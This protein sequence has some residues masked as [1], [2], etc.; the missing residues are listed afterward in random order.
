MPT[1]SWYFNPSSVCSNVDLHHIHR[2]QLQGNLV[3][4]ALL[5]NLCSDALQVMDWT[6]TPN[7]HSGCRV[8]NLERRQMCPASLAFVLPRIVTRAAGRLVLKSFFEHKFQRNA[9]RRRES[10]RIRKFCKGIIDFEFRKLN[11]R[12]DR[13]LF[14]FIVARP[15]GD[16]IFIAYFSP[17]AQHPHRADQDVLMR[18]TA[19]CQN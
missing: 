7:L 18:K 11:S 4:T 14:H 10:I 5:R 19:Y 9:V 15:N 17:G 3:T 6:P 16:D 2:F 13:E 1:T 12:T 8:C